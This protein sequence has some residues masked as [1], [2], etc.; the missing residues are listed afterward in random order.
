VVSKKI[1][2]SDYTYYCWRKEYGGMR[3]ERTMNGRAFRILNIIDEFNR[4]CLSLK[5][6]RKIG[7]QDVIEELLNLFVFRAGGSQGLD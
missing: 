7:S 5:V 2:V 6:D 3:V 1:G 4:G